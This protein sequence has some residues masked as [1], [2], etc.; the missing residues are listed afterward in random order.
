MSIIND[1][2]RK[3]QK[4]REKKNVFAKSLF[5]EELKEPPA[6]K[7]AYMRLQEDIVEPQP[8][9]EPVR[10]KTTAPL[11]FEPAPAFAGPS[12][13]TMT[14]I[15]SEGFSAVSRKLLGTPKKKETALVVLCS[16]ICLLLLIAIIQ[17]VVFNIT[18]SK[19]RSNMELKGIV[20]MDDR[21]VV[22]INDRAYEVGDSI[23]GMKIVDISIDQVKFRS[24]GGRIHTLKVVK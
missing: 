14:D 13:R 21:N 18:N 10:P 7:R 11:L 24:F 5:D 16:F 17:L 3:V 9:P 15:I 2:L 6:F 4:S 8:E 1:A 12:P 23:Y 20:L 22:L 19:Q